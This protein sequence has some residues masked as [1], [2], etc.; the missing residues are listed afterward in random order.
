MINLS[1][2][3]PTIEGGAPK[4]LLYAADKFGKSTFASQA[5]NPIFLDLDKRLKEIKCSKIPVGSFDDLI[6]AISALIKQEHAFKT[7]VLDSGG[8]AEQLAAKAVVAEYNAGK[9]ADKQVDAVGSIPY[10][11]GYPALLTKWSRLLNGLQLLNDKGMIILMLCH[12]DYIDWENSDG[13]KFK[14]YLPDLK[15]S[16]DK[17]GSILSFTRKWMDATIYGHQPRY[18]QSIQDGFDKKKVKMVAGAL[19]DRQLCTEETA[20]WVAG[21]SYKLPE[22]IPFPEV[23][24]WDNLYNLIKSTTIT[25][26]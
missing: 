15:G 23:G 21:N 25:K 14:R 17:A 6:E 7:V 22:S 11:A 18:N 16:S 4:I 13:T 24:A 1:E 8:T 9:P 20:L 5:P 2:I 3:I 26:E 12:A 10:G 19:G